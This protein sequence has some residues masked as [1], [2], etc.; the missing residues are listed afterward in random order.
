MLINVFNKSLH[1][2]FCPSHYDYLT[3]LVTKVQEMLKNWISNV[4]QQTN[5]KDF[6][7]ILI[8]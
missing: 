3:I 8:T 6:Y 5:L 1:V 2:G 4:L 7:H